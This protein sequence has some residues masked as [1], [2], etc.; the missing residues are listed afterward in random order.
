MFLRRVGKR[1]VTAGGER[2]KKVVFSHSPSLQSEAH[3]LTS[4]C[5]LTIPST[6]SRTIVCTHE[7]TSHT[8]STLRIRMRRPK[9]QG[10]R[11][12]SHP[13][14]VSQINVCKRT[15]SIQKRNAGEDR[16]DWVSGHSIWSSWKATP[17]VTK[18]PRGISSSSVLLYVHMQRPYG[19]LVHLDFHTAPNSDEGF[20]WMSL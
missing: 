2:N 12:Q 19:L 3:P 6:G 17:T 16:E 10:K 1:Q 8:V 5:M 9:W 4:V 14:F 20:I 18:F 11:H 7:T 13:Q 15:T